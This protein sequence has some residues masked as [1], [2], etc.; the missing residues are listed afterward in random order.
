MIQRYI[1]LTNEIDTKNEY[2]HNYESKSNYLN[3]KLFEYCEIYLVSGRV[4]SCYNETKQ[5]PHEEA[6]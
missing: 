1:G 5:N 4:N 3:G 6:G 2:R